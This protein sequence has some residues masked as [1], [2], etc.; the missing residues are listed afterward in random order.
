M[1]HPRNELDGNMLVA[2]QV[3]ALQNKAAAA[4][5]RRQRTVSWRQ[6]HICSCD[7]G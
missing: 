4:P 5:A 7:S 2:L 6:G 3:L 1:A